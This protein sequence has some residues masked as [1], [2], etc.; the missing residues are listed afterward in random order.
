MSLYLV[1]FIGERRSL[2]QNIFKK[3]LLF[4]GKIDHTK[5]RSIGSLENYP[6]ENAVSPCKKGTG[7]PA[8]S[9]L[10]CY[11]H[12]PLSHRNFEWR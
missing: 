6:L 12:R 9:P 2:P 5:Q 11:E 1:F 7:I 3:S 10:S 4:I 8:G